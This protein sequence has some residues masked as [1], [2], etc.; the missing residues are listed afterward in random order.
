M[1]HQNNSAAGQVCAVELSI[2]GSVSFGE[3]LLSFLEN[4]SLSFSCFAVVLL[5]LPLCFDVCVYSVIPRSQAGVGYWRGKLCQPSLIR[6]KEP[7]TG[8]WG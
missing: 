3:M 1:E 2:S 8:Q 6:E 4:V 7:R 5:K